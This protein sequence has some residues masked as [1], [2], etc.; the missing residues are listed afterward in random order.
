MSF[1]LIIF[2]FLSSIVLS[3]AIILNGWIK[4]ADNQINRKQ[5]KTEQSKFI[6]QLLN[7]IKKLNKNIS[8]DHNSKNKEVII[9]VDCEI[10]EESNSNT[11][12]LYLNNNEK[13]DF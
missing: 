2:I 6:I 10:I 11:K 13:R 12:Y 9:D 8:Q 4:F 3:S 7:Q 5:N 1:D